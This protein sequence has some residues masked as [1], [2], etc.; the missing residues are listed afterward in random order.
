VWRPIS[1]P[2]GRRS[3]EMGCWSVL[4][5]VGKLVVGTSVI[6]LVFQSSPSFNPIGV[7]CNLAP[8]H[9]FLSWAYFGRQPNVRVQCLDCISAAPLSTHRHPFCFEIFGF[10]LRNICVAMIGIC[11]PSAMDTLIISYSCKCQTNPMDSKR[12]TRSSANIFFE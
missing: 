4:L 5:F 11:I 8:P 10:I 12:T 6:H 9:C 3:S 7:P 1:R 2:W